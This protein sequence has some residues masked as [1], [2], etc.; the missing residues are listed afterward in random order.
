MSKL[1][2]AGGVVVRLDKDEPNYLIITA[3]NNPDHKIL[4][5]GH[6]EA[7]ET[8]A[9]T[10]LREIKEEAGIEG[11][12]ISLINSIEISVNDESFKIKFYLIKYIRDVNQT[13]Q[14]K[15]FWLH[16]NDALNFL[17]FEESRNLLRKAHAVTLKYLENPASVRVE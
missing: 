14:R 6:I 4:P 1:T 16:Y 17:S 2:H 12:I 10:A 8:P 9:D 11:E 7:G 13:E 3:R 15:I 5:K